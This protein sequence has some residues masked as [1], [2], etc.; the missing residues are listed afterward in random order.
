M[1][2]AVLQSRQ[3]LEEFMQATGGADLELEIVWTGNPSS[4]A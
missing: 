3:A 4:E 2:S 1:Q